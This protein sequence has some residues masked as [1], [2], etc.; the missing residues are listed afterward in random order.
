LSAPLNPPLPPPDEYPRRS[1]ARRIIGWIA[2]SL[3]T[4]VI[5]LAVAAVVVLRSNRF[6]GY[7][8]HTAEQ[9]ASEALGSQ[10]Q[11]QNFALHL[12]NLSLDIYGITVHGASPHPD[13][14]LLQVDQVEL[15]VRIISVLH[16]KWYLDDVRVVHPVVRVFADKQGNDNLP[17]TKSNGGSRT[18]VFDLAVRHVLLSRGEIYYSSQKS[19]L[20]AD[21]HDLSFQSTFDTGERR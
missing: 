2:A 11:V 1:R 17:K 5:I 4:I 8:L 20:N 3:L 10:V 9:K 7:I 12:S 14:P 19:V 13:P 16:R 18:S 21:L 6:H 15:G